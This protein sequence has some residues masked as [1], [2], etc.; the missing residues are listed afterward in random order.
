[1][2]SDKAPWLIAGIVGFYAVLGLVLL[3]RESMYSGDIGV[4]YVQARALVDERFTTLD[5]PYP[6]QF[7]DPERNFF[8][9]RPP[10]V[11]VTGGTTQAIFPPAAAMIQAGA[12]AVFGFK[13]LIALSIVAAGIVLIA[14]WK[15]APPDVGVAVLVAL[16]LAGPLWFYA[17]IGAEY[18]PALAFGTA[19]FAVAASSVGR[20]WSPFIAGALVGTGATLR[21]EVILLVPGL[22]MVV[23]FRDR[24]RRP[25]LAAADAVVPTVARGWASA[26]VEIGTTI[27]GVL[28]PLLLAATLEV[29]WFGRPP[30]AHL[31]HAVHIVQTALHLTSEP[32]LDVPVL[33]PMTLRERYFTVV[34]YWLL[35]RGTD[36]QVA[37]FCGALLIALAVWW[38]WRSSLGILVWLLA[39]GAT[40]ATDLWEVVMRPKFLAGLIRVAPFVVFAVLPIARTQAPSTSRTSDVWL[41]WTM[42]FTAAAYL[43]IAFAGVDTTGG[44]SLGP[45][46]LL[47][48]LPLLTVSS[49]IAISSFVRS[50][51]VVDRA[52]GWVGAALVAMGLVIHLGGTVPAYRLRN[53]DDASAVIAAA[54]SPERIVVAD[55]MFTAQLLFPLYDRKII[56]LADTP[57]RGE[58]LG[59]LLAG[60]RLSGALLVSRNPE[61][62]VTL[63]PLRVDRTEQRGRMVLQY[64]R[65]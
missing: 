32:N 55:D 45:R 19:A 2:A 58:R 64:W 14:S 20:K 33:R 35:G 50:S 48:L 11:M 3:A 5:I 10:F 61:P 47:P 43:V 25:S 31:R 13:G 37:S 21:D 65:R 46:L 30:A 16:G 28:L 22:L 29:A 42:G 6:G 8:P 23:W 34:T 26:G 9:L 53:A 17:V 62:T 12:V 7:L 60:E 49:I 38:R 27:A 59:S 1:M 15:L 54:A 57:E 44:K 4:K 40:A 36:Q 24:L 18:A 56:F 51:G 63:P 52:V 39:I 41:R